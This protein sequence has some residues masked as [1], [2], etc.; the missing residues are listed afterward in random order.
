LSTN[1]FQVISFKNAFVRLVIA[2]VALSL[3][4]FGGNNALRRG[5]QCYSYHFRIK[6]LW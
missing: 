4:T 6:S 5:C 2:L 1:R 3:Q